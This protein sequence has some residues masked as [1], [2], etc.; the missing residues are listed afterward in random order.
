MQ[1]L[2]GLFFECLGAITPVLIIY[3]LWKVCKIPF[4]RK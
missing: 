4:W 3:F 2:I 1:Q